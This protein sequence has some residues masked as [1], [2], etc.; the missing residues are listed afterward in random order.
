[1]NVEELVRYWKDPEA[2]A[3]A[4]T[5]HPAGEITLDGRTRSGRRAALLAGLGGSATGGYHGAANTVMPH[6][7][8]ISSPS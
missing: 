7:T 3:G 8:S 4:A 6:G 2:R 1:M 5:G